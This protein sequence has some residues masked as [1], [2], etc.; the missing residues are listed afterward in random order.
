MLPISFWQTFYMEN[1]GIKIEFLFMGP[2]NDVLSTSHYVM[3]N[4]R[5]NAEEVGSMKDEK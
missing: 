2:Y 1:T 5:M 4:E 3:L